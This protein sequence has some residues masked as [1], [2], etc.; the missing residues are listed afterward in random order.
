[1]VA[2]LALA[3]LVTGELRPYRT[4]AVY[5]EK[6]GFVSRLLAA[7]GDVVKEG[8]VLAEVAGDIGEPPMEIRAPFA[9]VVAECYA[10]TGVRVGPGAR[11]HETQVFDIAEVARLKLVAAVPHALPA[12]ARVEFMVKGRRHA[13]T[14]ERVVPRVGVL[15]AEILVANDG[16]EPGMEVQVDWP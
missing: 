1:V 3:T 10:Q 6:T 12:G 14:L 2:L 7:R 13:G 16:L 4:A 5:A 15:I 9:G 8:Q 11:R